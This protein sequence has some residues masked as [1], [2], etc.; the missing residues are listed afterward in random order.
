MTAAGV[1]G[2]GRVPITFTRGTRERPDASSLSVYNSP[3]YDVNFL[4][5]VGIFFISP[6]KAC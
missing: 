5:V 3:N 2:D 6:A 1:E 4:F